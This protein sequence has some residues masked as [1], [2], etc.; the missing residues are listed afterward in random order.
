MVRPL[1]SNPKHALLASVIAP[2]LAY[3]CGSDGSP[4]DRMSQANPGA[5]G[6]S[7]GGASS[8]GT[9]P[10]EESEM[11]G[12]APSATGGRAVDA[13]GGR[14]GDAPSG[15]QGRDAGA[16]GEPTTGSNDGGASGANGDAGRPSGGA[17]GSAG[18]SD[19]GGNGDVGGGGG[20][21]GSGGSSTA[22]T[23]SG[24]AAGAAATGGSGGAAG[25]AGAGGFGG[26]R[27]ANSLPCD[28]Q[29]V[30][31]ARCQPCH[32][33]PPLNGAPMR[34]LT[35]SDV[36]GK[37]DEMYA[38]LSADEMPPPGAPD[39]SRDQANTLFT[40]LSLGTPP[41]GTVTCR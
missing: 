10:R 3:G 22:G 39:L 19:V 4:N 17:A 9:S 5:S 11:D 31:K 32:Q 6:K 35:W 20:S 16:A 1:L 13:E 15:D 18:T 21:G 29:A 23:G 14:G 41:A 12:G 30:L 33:A 7:V 40:Y 34:L 37:A 2:M 24:G 8:A 27:P 38:K 36:Y 28:V 25:A 26:A